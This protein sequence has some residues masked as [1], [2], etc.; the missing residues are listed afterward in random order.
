MRLKKEILY[1]K[2]NYISIILGSLFVG[3]TIFK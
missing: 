3:M 2:K 1:I